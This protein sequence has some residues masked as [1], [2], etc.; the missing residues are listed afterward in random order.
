MN[1]VAYNLNY[2]KFNGT[3]P[4]CFNVC[5]SGLV[6][7]QYYGAC[8]KN[9]TAA[10]YNYSGYCLATCPA[11]N[12]AYN[13]SNLC[14]TTCP[15]GY[16]KNNKTGTGAGIC[17][18]PCTSWG[19]V[20]LYGDNSTGTCVNTCPSGIYADP[21]TN[22]CVS[23]CNLTGT[24]YMYGQLVKATIGMAAYSVGTCVTMCTTNYLST[25]ISYGNPLTGF[26]VNASDC[27]TNYFGDS[28]VGSTQ[29]MC[30]E[31][32]SG[33]HEYGV[34]SSKKCETSCGPNSNVT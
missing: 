34:N 5:P 12:Y 6:A 15:E 33:I 30:V 24:T 32:C 3:D 21:S 25:G 28:S 27:P 10:Y 17:E 14:V 16:F 7:D 2:Y 26:C 1:G 23:F 29:N 20:N 8:L 11:S 13:V 4:A 18:Y 22:M 9:C 19:G 31:T